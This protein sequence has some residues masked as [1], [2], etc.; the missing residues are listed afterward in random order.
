M[1]VTGDGGLGF[2]SGEGAYKPSFLGSKVTRECVASAPCG[3]NTV[4]LPGNPEAVSTVWE[5]KLSIRRRGETHGHG[6][7][8]ADGDNRQPN[9]TGI[10]AHGCSSQTKCQWAYL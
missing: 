9:P 2:D 4:K 1:V 10:T 8:L 7:N 6:K 5:G 3:C